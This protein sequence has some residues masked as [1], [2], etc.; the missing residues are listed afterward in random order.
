MRRIDFILLSLS[1]LMLIH[2]CSVFSG[3]SQFTNLSTSPSSITTDKDIS[4][5]DTA[6]KL[7]LNQPVQQ[8]IEYKGNV[9]FFTF[10]V[11]QNMFL[12]IKVDSIPNPLDLEMYVLDAQSYFIASAN[13]GTTNSISYSKTFS[14]GKYYVVV[15]D[16]TDKNMSNLKYTISLGEILTDKYGDNHSVE[17]ASPILINSVITANLFEKDGNDFFVFTLNSPT[18]INF[19]LIC[20]SNINLY[21]Y[22]LD[23]ASHNWC[24][25]EYQQN[26]GQKIYIFK[27]SCLAGTYYLQINN[28]NN[29]TPF[30]YQLNFSKDESDPT[31]PNDDFSL[32]IPIQLNQTVTSNLHSEQ[33]FDY[34]TFYIDHSMILKFSMISSSNIC[35]DVYTEDKQ[36]YQNNFFPVGKYYYRLWAS[37]FTNYSLKIEE[38]QSYPG[39]PNNNKETAT[40]ISLNDP[41]VGSFYR[42]DD[43][44]YYK[45]DIPV[46]SKV[47]IEFLSIP[48][49]FVLNGFIENSNSYNYWWQIQESTKTNEV[50]LDAGTYY[51]YLLG[52][53]I[54]LDKAYS[55]KITATPL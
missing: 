8:M 50:T 31:E 17:K 15:K 23:S 27:K 5:Y 13:A 4:S 12:E 29:D 37:N 10:T 42:S 49:S 1:L 28:S 35:C 55:F 6:Q 47:L 30:H 34:Y 36:T 18:V 38:D 3:K 51:F 24:S 19:N 21:L 40:F 22:L 16:K 33:D 2:G 25:N 52:Y 54:D 53:F 46:R 43:S 20:P 11:T 41:I 48:A 9:D 45:F 39:E 32:A 7:E 44:D 14:A 26:G